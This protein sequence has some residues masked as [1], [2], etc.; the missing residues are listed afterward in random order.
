MALSD[1]PGR[2]ML[3]GFYV[4]RQNA[5]TADQRQAFSQELFDKFDRHIVEALEAADPPIEDPSARV[6]ASIA[7]MA[8]NAPG[9]NN[10]V[11]ARRAVQ[12]YLDFKGS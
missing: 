4:E 7:V 12:A 5:G 6:R 10:R 1:Y 9:S 8:Q 2:T 3:V 11:K